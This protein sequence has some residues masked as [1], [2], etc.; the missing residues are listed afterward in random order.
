MKK[1]LNILSFVI[2]MGLVGSWECDALSFGELLF[3]SGAILSLLMIL[4][5]F[6]ALFFIVMNNKKIKR[7]IIKERLV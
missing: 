1:I 2:I 6:Y 4:H 7:K 3:L 5:V